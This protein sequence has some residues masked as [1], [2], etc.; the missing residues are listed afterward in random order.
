MC[1]GQTA[2]HPVGVLR[3][4][5]P[6]LTGK[7][8]PWF[9]VSFTFLLHKGSSLAIEAAES[10]VGVL[11]VLNTRPVSSG[12]VFVFIAGPLRRW[13]L[14]CLTNQPDEEHRHQHR[15][16]PDNRIEVHLGNFE[17][18]GNPGDSQTTSVKSL[19]KHTLKAKKENSHTSPALNL[20]V[21]LF[22]S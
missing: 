21:V 6:V 8:R 4:G 9:L 11:L 13:R 14:C 12:E 1:A 20:S 22:F 18:G 19:K 16:F 7:T 15:K 2:V 10:I 17:M 3:V 5:L